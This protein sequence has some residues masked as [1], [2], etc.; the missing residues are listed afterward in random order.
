[1]RNARASSSSSVGPIEV[2]LLALG[3]ERHGAIHRAGV[4]KMKSQPAGQAAGT[5]LLP[6]PAGPSMVTIMPLSVGDSPP[7]TNPQRISPGRHR[8]DARAGE[9]HRKGAKIAKQ[10]YL[11]SELMWPRRVLRVFAGD[12]VLQRRV[13]HSG[14]PRVPLSPVGERVG[15]V[16]VRGLTCQAR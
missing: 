2:D 14:R 10:T 3:R 16:G 9:I 4:E 15:R 5:L 13:G 8:E 7:A 6:A 11:G 12:L 1:M